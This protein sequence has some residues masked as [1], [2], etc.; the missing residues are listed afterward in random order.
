MNRAPAPH[1]A[2]AD[3][4][5]LVTATG[6]SRKKTPSARAGRQ[7]PGE[8]WRLVCRE[9]SGNGMTPVSSHRKTRMGGLPSAKH[10]NIAQQS[11]KLFFA[12]STG[13]ARSPVRS[14]RSVRHPV[15]DVLELAEAV[16]QARGRGARVKVA[17]LRRSTTSEES[18]PIKTSS[19]ARTRS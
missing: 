16:L 18:P 19:S 4:R 1:A 9:P 3:R 10:A 14:L 2:V 15:I 12:A 5:R 17:R 11:R 6:T 8:S 13:Q 7:L